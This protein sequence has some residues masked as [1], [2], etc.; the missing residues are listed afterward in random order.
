MCTEVS[1]VG[2]RP[3]PGLPTWDKLHMGKEVGEAGCGGVAHVLVKFSHRPWWPR[4]ARRSA[5]SSGWP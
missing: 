2:G 3:G 5:V 1:G 4:D